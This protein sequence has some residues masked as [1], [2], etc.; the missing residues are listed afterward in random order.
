MKA[1][2]SKPETAIAGPGA[3]L[4]RWQHL[5]DATLITPDVG[6][7]GRVRGGGFKSVIKASEKGIEGQEELPESDTGTVEVP[8]DSEE[9]SKG[10]EQDPAD[11]VKEAEEAGS[12]GD[13]DIFEDAS[14]RLD[15][16]GLS[17]DDKKTQDDLRVDTK[18]IV[19]ALGKQ[20]RELLA[21]RSCNW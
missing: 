6:T 9:K 7:G 16:L 15:A 14:E 19:D 4:A 1:T 11:A 13:E 5:L 17:G 20:F 10:S 21:K 12:S 3:Y 2:N 8:D 18:P